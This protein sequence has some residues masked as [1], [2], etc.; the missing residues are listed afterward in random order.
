MILFLR[1]EIKCYV[2]RKKEIYILLLKVVMGGVLQV[3]F[4]FCNVEF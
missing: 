1:R 3:I 4:V 2:F